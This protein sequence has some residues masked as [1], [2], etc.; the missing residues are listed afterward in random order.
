LGRPGA[1]LAGRFS[2]QPDAVTQLGGLLEC[3]L[4]DGA[5]QP[6]FQ[7]FYFRYRP[8]FLDISKQPA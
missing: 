8:F 4:L 5:L 2:Q 3:L 1:A 7:P 6:P